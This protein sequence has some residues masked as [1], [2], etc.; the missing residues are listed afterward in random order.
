MY[1]WNVGY[2]QDTCNIHMNVLFK[3]VIYSIYTDIIPIYRA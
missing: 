1:V 2:I 3:I